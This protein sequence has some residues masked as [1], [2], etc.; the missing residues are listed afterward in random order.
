M[1]SPGL[2]PILALAVRPLSGPATLE[3]GIAVTA[4]SIRRHRRRGAIP[5]SQP[6]LAYLP[7]QP[8][9]GHLGCRSLRGSDPDQLCSAAH[10]SARPSWPSLW[11]DAPPPVVQS[12]S[13][14]SVRD[15]TPE[16]TERVNGTGIT[17]GVVE[18]YYLGQPHRSLG[19]QAPL[20]KERLGKPTGEVVCRWRR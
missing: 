7:C 18:Y 5:A 17:G 16:L 15:G 3:R 20:G 12:S 14:R 1:A 2:E 9:P 6:E 19:L 13:A 8:R 4:R 10:Q 11:A